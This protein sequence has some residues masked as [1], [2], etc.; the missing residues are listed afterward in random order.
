LTVLSGRL[1]LLARR[2]ASTSADERLAEHAERAL[3][4]ARH[5]E[6]DIDELMDAARLQFGKIILD[7]AAT[8]LVTIVQRAAD[9]AKTLSSGQTIDVDTPDGAVMID[10]DARRLERVLVNV[11][12][13]ALIYAPGSERIDIRLRT[14]AEQ[15]VVEVQDRGPGIPA[16]SIADIFSRFVRLEQGPTSRSGLGLGLFIAREIM[17]AHGGT[18]EAKSAVGEG[19]TI[20]MRL[21]MLPGE[22]EGSSSLAQ[23]ADRRKVS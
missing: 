10:G 17:T 19:T 13:N 2:L 11:L 21:P 15:A 20:V 9:T 16:A 23:S 4:Q 22:R 12:N 5:L 14:E 8:N 1:Q 18:I 7:R 3:E 6:A